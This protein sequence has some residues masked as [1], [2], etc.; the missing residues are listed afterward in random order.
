M[1]AAKP[2]VVVAWGDAD[3]QLGH[4]TGVGRLAPVKV[5]G[6]ANAISIGATTSASW[7]TARRRTG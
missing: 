6:I 5:P 3:G 4:G 2:G 1:A 7:A